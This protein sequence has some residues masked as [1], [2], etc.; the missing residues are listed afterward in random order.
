MTGTFRIN[1]TFTL[2]NDDA[3]EQVSVPIDQLEAMRAFLDQE[4]LMHSVD[5]ETGITV[6]LPR[7]GFQKARDRFRL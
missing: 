4:R 5:Y 6:S 3:D 1:D 7:R 2:N